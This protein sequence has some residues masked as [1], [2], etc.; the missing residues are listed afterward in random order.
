ML[1]I[2]F[3]FTVANTIFVLLYLINFYKHETTLSHQALKNCMT[4]LI[5]MVITN[6]IYLI[7]T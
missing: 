5:I 7:L 2:I 4:I 1:I 3:M 6:F